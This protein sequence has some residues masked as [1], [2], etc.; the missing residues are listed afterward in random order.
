MPHHHHHGG[1]HH[2]H[3]HGY[4]RGPVVVAGPRY[5]YGAGMGVGMMEGMMIGSMMSQPR[6]TVV[7]AQPQT[8]VVQ[9]QPQ[10]VYQQ[11]Q[12]QQQAPPKPNVQL[13]PNW[14][15]K[16]DPSSNRWYYVDHVNKK[17]QWEPPAIQVSAPTPLY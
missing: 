7:Q 3:H 9:A 8:V 1:H 17:T 15:C 13:P 6:T 11:P 10:P 4:R 14:E 2:H 5:G 16:F 12:V